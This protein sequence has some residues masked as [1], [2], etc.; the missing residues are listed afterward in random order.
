MP[1]V[2]CP[3]CGMDVDERNVRYHLRHCGASPVAVMRYPDHRPSV[4]VSVPPPPPPPRPRPRAEH[5]FMIPSLDFASAIFGG[6]MFFGEGGFGDGVGGDDYESNLRIQDAL[7]GNVKKAV[8]DV[9][10]AAPMVDHG[11]SEECA[12]CLSEPEG[13]VRKGKACGHEFCA[14]CIEK[15]LSEHTTCPVCVTDLSVNGGYKL[16]DSQPQRSR[17]SD[18][19]DLMHRVDTIAAILQSLG[20]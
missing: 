1:F 12:I 20:S 9:D 17:G 3:S 14:E 16:V 10:E 18:V 4:Y 6:D 7:G 19:S 13:G 11:L 15:W 5:P 2:R 8:R